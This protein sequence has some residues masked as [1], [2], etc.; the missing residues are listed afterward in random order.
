MFN[1]KKALT[2][3]SGIDLTPQAKAKQV[4]GRTRRP[5]EGKIKAVWITPVDVGD[6]MSMRY[7]KNRMSEY[8]ADAN[9]RVIHGRIR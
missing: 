2:V 6:Y 7:F 9:I 4:L 1:V 3:A 8:N 5:Y